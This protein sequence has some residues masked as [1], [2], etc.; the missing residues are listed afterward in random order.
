ML[1]KLKKLYRTLSSKGYTIVYLSV[2]EDDIFYGKVKI[3]SKSLK[4]TLKKYNCD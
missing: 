4:K 2:P 3:T 1:H